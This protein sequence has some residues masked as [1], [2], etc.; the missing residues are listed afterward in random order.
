VKQHVVEFRLRALA[1]VE[2][3]VSYDGQTLNRLLL[4]SELQTARM[5]T[6]I[7]PA[8]NPT[9][10]EQAKNRDRPAPELNLLAQAVAG[11]SNR[12]L[13]ERE[14]GGIRQ[15][16]HRLVERVAPWEGGSPPH[17]DRAGDASSAVLTLMLGGCFIIV[18]TFLI[19]GYRVQRRAIGRERQRQAALTSALQQWRNQLAA[20]VPRLP[21][22]RP[23]PRSP[24]LPEALAPVAIRRRVRMAQKTRW[25]V[26]VG[27]LGDSHDLTQEPAG[28]PI[29]PQLRTSRCAPSAPI[30]LLEALAQLRGA[31]MRLQGKPTMSTT[32]NQTPAVSKQAPR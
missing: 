6:A 3:E 7:A 10:P 23:D 30:E 2:L 29:R 27:A 24:A 14:L 21:A 20:E 32:A 16:I 19:M 26:R 18:V 13:I 15:E 11:A 4:K 5:R 28:E 9:L 1:D 25:Q 17:E 22:L 8:P 12:S 31:L